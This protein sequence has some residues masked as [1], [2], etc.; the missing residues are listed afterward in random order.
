MLEI[1]ISEV[2]KSPVGNI[3]SVCAAEL[4]PDGSM[5]PVFRLSRARVVELLKAGREIFTS[6]VYADANGKKWWPKNAR[7]VLHRDLY[8]TTA[9]TNTTRDNLDELPPCTC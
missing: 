6:L 3:E 5:G 9:A 8:I 2:Q 1:R 4:Q 7:V